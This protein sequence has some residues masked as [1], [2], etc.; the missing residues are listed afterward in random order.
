VCDV[1]IKSNSIKKM[2]KVIDKSSKRRRSWRE[3]DVGWSESGA[4][5]REKSEEEH[6]ESRNAKVEARVGGV[7]IYTLSMPGVHSLTVSLG[8]AYRTSKDHKAECA[9]TTTSGTEVDT[10]I[11]GHRNWPLSGSTHCGG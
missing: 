9:S 1:Y 10:A 6:I 8:G 5:C 11:V 7:L 2:R 4:R 3:V